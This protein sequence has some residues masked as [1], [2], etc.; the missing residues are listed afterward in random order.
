MSVLPF[1][2]NQEGNVVEMI[3]KQDNILVTFGAETTKW[4]CVGA[5]DITQISIAGMSLEFILVDYEL[6]NSMH[7]SW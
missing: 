5:I 2:E 1:L 7:L 6:G 4:I 3:C